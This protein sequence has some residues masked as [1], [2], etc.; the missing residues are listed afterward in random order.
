MGGVF[1]QIFCS[2]FSPA[3]V[4]VFIV[5]FACAL[6]P[7]EPDWRMYLFMY[8][9]DSFPPAPVEENVDHV[10]GRRPGR[11]PPTWLSCAPPTHRPQGELVA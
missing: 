6:L 2:E 4:S 7:G 1:C 8:L 3:S 11:T 10:C 9:L 5:G